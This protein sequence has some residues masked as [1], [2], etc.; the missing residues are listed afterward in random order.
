V[1][2]LTFDLDPNDSATE[3]TLEIPTKYKMQVS[4]TISSLLLTSPTILHRK[5]SSPHRPS[6]SCSSRRVFAIHAPSCTLQLSLYHHRLFALIANHLI[7]ILTHYV[8][9]Y[10]PFFLRRDGASTL[11]KSSKL[12]LQNVVLS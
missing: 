5:V 1:T 2:Q 12:Y 10:S 7:Q 8:V 3:V 4:P 11:G 9:R 6:G